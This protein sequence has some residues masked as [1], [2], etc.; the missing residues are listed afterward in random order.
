MRAKTA[1]RD[2]THNRQFQSFLV[3][4]TSRKTAMLALGQ[5]FCQPTCV[6]V[7][8]TDDEEAKRLRRSGEIPR[9]C[10]PRCR[11]REFYPSA[12]LRHRTTRPRLECS[13][14]TSVGPSPAHRVGF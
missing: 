11:F 9:M 13:P 6:I 12:I 14:K 3:T 7:I 5:G 4:G 10:A 2:P 1:T 8:S